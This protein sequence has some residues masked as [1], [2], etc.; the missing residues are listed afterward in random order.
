MRL[1]TALN[2]LRLL[3]VAVSGLYVKAV[4][5]ILLENSHVGL[6][7]VCVEGLLWPFE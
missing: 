2:I 1:R 5:M 6:V 7:T 4:L 3:G